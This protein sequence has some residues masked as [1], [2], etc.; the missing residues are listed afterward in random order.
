MTTPA[1]QVLELA[2]WAPSGDNTQP[3]RFELLGPDR[4]VVH[5]HDTRDDCVYDLD[6]HASQIAL[7]AL[8]ETAAIATSGQGMAL[9]A[10]RREQLPATTPTFDCVLRPGL[11]QA[12]SPLIEAI[13]YTG[14]ARLV[15]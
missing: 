6:G 4:F 2:R 1:E 3:W 13:R 9:E 12:P 11:G 7:G 14:P 10:S 15:T 8:L 5:G